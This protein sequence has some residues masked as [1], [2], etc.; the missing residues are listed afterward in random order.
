MATT[1]K[2]SV[3]TRNSTDIWLV[4]QISSSLNQTKLPSKREILSIFFHYKNQLNLNIRDSAHCT[5]ADVLIVWEKANIPTRLKKHV[6]D[7]IEGLFKEWQKLKKK[8]G[9]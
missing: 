8:Q 9:K 6:V 2:G 1:S 4:G 3:V 7:K 5:A